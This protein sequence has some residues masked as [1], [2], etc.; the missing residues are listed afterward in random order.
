MISFR[1]QL[2]LVGGANPSTSEYLAS[3]LVWDEQRHSWDE[4]YT[5]M[6]VARVQSS[7]VAQEP[8][9][10]A[11]GGRN[12][13]LLDSVEVFNGNNGQWQVVE[14]GRLPAKI[15][16]ATSAELNGFWYLIGGSE[17]KR[18]VYRASLDSIIGA[19]LRLRE[20]EIWER[21]PDLEFEYATA[22]SFGNCLLA[23]GGSKAIA[24]SE[25]VF[26][27]F[28]GRGV[29]LRME[30]SLPRPFHSS[31]AVVIPPGELL[32]IGGCT[33]MIRHKHVYKAVLK[34]AA[35]W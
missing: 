13:N 33:T 1:N 15:Y 5:S 22:A 24:S 16:A 32:V 9:I 28:P 21:L 17:Q 34:K 25:T 18:A 27:Y 6:N 29:W 35:A 8:H 19:A 10:V 31:A 3:L 26:G 20:D 4:P 11:A 23:I 30:Q 12:K 2:I 14:A 7:V